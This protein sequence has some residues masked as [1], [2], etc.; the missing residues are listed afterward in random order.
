V[1]ISKAILGVEG[2]EFYV[3]DFDNI[4]EKNLIYNLILGRPETK[5]SALEWWIKG[6]NNK[7]GKYPEKVEHF[8]DANGFITFL[9]HHGGHVFIGFINNRNNILLKCGDYHYD[10]GYNYNKLF[11]N[12]TPANY[13]TGLIDM[14]G[15]EVYEFGL[16]DYRYEAY[17]PNLHYC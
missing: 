1:K 10:T 9:L 15:D 14:F 4:I 3:A 12:F 6:I 13:K 16:H 8:S 2:I 5:E 11:C 17:E 7:I